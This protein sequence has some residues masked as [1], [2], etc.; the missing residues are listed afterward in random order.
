[1]KKL[2]WFGLAVAL[3]LAAFISPFACGWLD[4]LERVAEDKGF[5][6]AGEGPPLLNSP[7]PDYVFPGIA[8][9]RVATGIAGVV[10]TAGVFGVAFGLAAVLR[11]RESK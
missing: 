11:K 2:L 8:D 5:L 7:I 9:E 4:G 3:C 1:M 10:G 6:T